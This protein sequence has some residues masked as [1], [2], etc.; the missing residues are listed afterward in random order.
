M[1]CGKCLH[2]NENVVI[3]WYLDGLHTFGIY[4]HACVLEFQ[5]YVRN[6]LLI[7]TVITL[8]HTDTHTQ[9]SLIGAIEVECRLYSFCYKRKPITNLTSIFLKLRDTT[10]FHQVLKDFGI[11]EWSYQQWVSYDTSQILQRVLQSNLVRYCIASYWTL[12]KYVPDREECY[13]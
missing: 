6:Y 5:L 7:L 9:A 12:Q 2:H 1:Q 4:Y 11:E 10:T 3:M 8:L 13:Y